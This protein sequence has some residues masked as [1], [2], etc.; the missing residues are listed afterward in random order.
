[1]IEDTSKIFK[2]NDFSDSKGG[3][4]QQVKFLMD[5]IDNDILSKFDWII[6]YPVDG[7]IKD[8]E[9]KSILYIH[10]LAEDPAFGV[11]KYKDTQ[12]QYDYFVFVSYTQKESFRIKFNIPYEKCIVMKNCVSP[13]ESST[14]KFDNLDKIKI[15]YTS[16]PHKGL[17]IVYEVFRVLG[18]ELKDAVELNVYSNFDLYGSKHSPRNEPYEGLYQKMRDNENINYHG[19][20]PH[21]VLM[22]SLK[23]NHIWVNP[24][25]FPET[26]C[27]SLMEAASASCMC[28]HN[29]LGALPETSSS[30]TVMYRHE[31]SPNKHASVFYENIINII[32]A[33]KDFTDITKRHLNLQKYYF[34]SFYSES[35]RIKEWEIFLT[36]IID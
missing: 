3:T 30:F 7:F 8:E 33:M 16:A 36:S 24:S 35:R 29:D 26:S 27:K 22:E 2:Y 14:D 21:D 34:D 10:D 13:I 20:V 25:L 23:E 17:P 11:L 19:Y 5:N 4:E 6:S 1:M 32:G 9:R 31:T 18:E 28:I 15:A 12:D